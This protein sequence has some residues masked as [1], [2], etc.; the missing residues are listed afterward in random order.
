LSFLRLSLAA[1]LCLSVLVSG[2]QV[3]IVADSEDYS[4]ACDD[5]DTA[6][7]LISGNFSVAIT[8]DWPRVIFWHTT[9]IFGPTFEVGFPRMYLYND[10]DGNGVFSRSEATG[11]IYLDSL[12][13]VWTMT[14][15]E[16]G[17]T[18]TSGKYA[19]FSMTSTVPCYA[20]VGNDTLEI[21]DW[22]EVR[23]WFTLCENPMVYENSRGEY[24]V[25]GKTELRSNFSVDLYDCTDCSGVVLE[26]SLQGGGSTNMFLLREQLGDYEVNY[27]EASGT[28]DQ[29]L[30]GANFTNP[31]GGTDEPLQEI[32]LS[33]E[34]GTVQAVYYWN[35]EA[36]LANA[37]QE[38]PSLVS[39]SY[40]TTGT[41]LILHTAISTNNSTTL[42]HDSIVGI[43]ES[44]FIGRITDW[45]KEHVVELAAVGALIVMVVA[46]M[47]LVS[48]RRRSRGRSGEGLGNAS[49]DGPT[50]EN[51]V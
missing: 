43:I 14:A 7:N 45:A 42:S 21:H 47:V 23:F 26:Q 20:Q 15:V 3:S 16:T 8:R 50:D 37:T 12:Y 34:D 36:T 51:P 13:A 11:T 5:G 27:T 2:A 35:S 6:V 38:H 39:S 33:K 49:G 17:I 25:R 19:R 48:R 24:T 22:A 4:I 44:G 32:K 29:T 10:S 31:L 9:D 30:L 41:G 1:G 18:P 46:L 28:V 40:Y